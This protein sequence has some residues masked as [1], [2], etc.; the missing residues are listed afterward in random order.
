MISFALLG[1]DKYGGDLQRFKAY[2]FFTPSTQ[3]KDMTLTVTESVHYDHQ[4]Y[5]LNIP[6]EKIQIIDQLIYSD[7]LIR[8]NTT[9]GLE[10]VIDLPILSTTISDTEKKEDSGVFIGDLHLG[11]NYTLP[12]NHKLFDLGISFGLG[13]PTGDYEHYSGLDGVSVKTG[14]FSRVYLG[15]L[16]LKAAAGYLVQPKSTLYSAV[17]ENELYYHLGARFTLVPNML[18]TTGMFMGRLKADDLTDAAVPLEW[19]HTVDY[20]L[21][22]VQLQAGY[23]IGLA[24]GVGTPLF[25]ALFAISYHHN[26]SQK[27][28]KSDQL[29]HDQDQDGILDSQDQCKNEK[30]TVNGFKDQDGCPDTKPVV[31]KPKKGPKLAPK[32][33]DPVSNTTKPKLKP[34]K[35]VT[36]IV[37]EQDI[38]QD[39]ILDH[40]D[41]CLNKKENFN[42]IKDN[43]GCPDK[44]GITVVPDFEKN[45]IL[46]KSRF[47]FNR[48]R[49]SKTE[50]RVLKSIASLIKNHHQINKIK[51]AVHAD[52]TG[53]DKRQLKRT[54]QKGYKI[55]RYLTKRLKLKKDQIISE[56]FGN[57]QVIRSI[58]PMYK[59]LKKKPKKKMKRKIRKMIR[60]GKKQNRRIEWLIMTGSKPTPAKVVA[61]PEVKKIDVKVDVKPEPVKKEVKKETPK[62]KVFPKVSKKQKRGFYKKAR[63]ALKKKQY[64][65]AKALFLTLAYNFKKDS[66]PYGALMVIYKKLKD[67]KKSKRCKKAFKKL[68]KK[69]K[70]RIITPKTL[71][72]WYQ[73]A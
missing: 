45:V 69:R 56:G 32:T 8:F 72:Q 18:G 30:E 20:Q 7:L 37:K 68:R 35:I 34:K 64:Q 22:S 27:N 46:V 44:G 70:N 24:N 2:D 21:S 62:V 28:I 14:L 3:S 23:S 47:Q 29:S 59:A 33:A 13:L 15:P 65:K 16:T 53:R 25:R 61:K 60:A 19:V 36:P 43:D 39:G 17:I 6:G 1:A 26:F 52:G 71:Q 31:K 58:K 67:F 4:P 63:T 73:G 66:E 5:A 42:G 9:F 38:D 11:F 55:V 48:K 12:L 50:R 49:P 40:K 10:T 54:K 57:Q 51:V 41:K